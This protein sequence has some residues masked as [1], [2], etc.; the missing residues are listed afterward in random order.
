MFCHLFVVFKGVGRVVGGAYYLDVELF[1]Q[2]LAAVFRT[3]ELLGAFVIDCTCRGRVQDVIN[4]EHPCQFQVSPVIQRVAHR[5]WHRF[6]PF[7]EFL[8]T[9]SVP[10]N[11]FFRHSVAPHCPPFVMVASEPDFRKILESVVL[12]NHFRDKMAV[13]VDDRHLFSA[14]MIKFACIAV[15]QHEILMDEFPVEHAVDFFFYIG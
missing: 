1:H 2:R 10:G 8:V 5:I 15:R 12:G 4:A 14:F 11:E 9:A 13:I 7:F 6:S 3:L